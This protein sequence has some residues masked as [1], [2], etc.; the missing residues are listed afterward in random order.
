MASTAGTTGLGVAPA[1]RT[2]RHS[3]Q[4][5]ASPAASMSVL[6]ASLGGLGVLSLLIGAWG[7]IAPY[8]GPTFGYDPTGV[9]AWHWAL[10]PGVLALVPGAVAV[11]AAVLLLG[12]ARRQ[13]GVGG[14]GL[15][16]VLAGGWFVIGPLAWPVL[17]SSLPYFAAGPPLRELSYQVG[18]NLGPGLILAF[19]GALGIGWTLRHH[20]AS[21]GTAVL[22]TETAVGVGSAPA[23]SEVDNAAARPSEPAPT[24]SPAEN[25]VAPPSVPPFPQSP[26]EMGEPADVPQQQ[27]PPFGS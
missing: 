26:T 22:D 19:C 15:L 14:A 10:E 23:V 6:P 12:G 24:P 13:A 1:S 7:G 4:V 20:A 2:G 25:V 16:L 27:V 3:R 8:V 11:L 5:V 18:T 21:T 9:T 17:V